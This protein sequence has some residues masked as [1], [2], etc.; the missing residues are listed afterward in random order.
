MLRLPLVEPT[1]LL[2][3]LAASI[4]R[5]YRDED[6]ARTFAE[7][8]RDLSHLSLITLDTSLAELTV[9]IAA[10]HRLRGSDAVYAAVA[11]RYGTILVTLDQE[12]YERVGGVVPTQTPAQVVAALPDDAK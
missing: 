5:V 3:E 1:L 7:S 12:Q 2:P 9:D 11:K 6:L 4:A 8:I 10:R